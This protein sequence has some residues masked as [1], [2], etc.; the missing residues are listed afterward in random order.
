MYLGA[1][2]TPGSVLEMCRDQPLTRTRVITDELTAPHAGEVLLA[3]ERFGLSSNN[4]S[5]A[6]LGDMLGHWKPFPAAEGWGR[7]PAWGVG[8]VLAADPSVAREGARFAGYMPMATHVLMQ[9][10]STDAGLRDTSLERAGMLPLYRELRAVDDDP[11][12]REEAI[13]LELAMMPVEPLA[14]LLDEDLRRLAVTHVVISSASSKTAMGLGHLLRE[15]SVRVTGLSSPR[16]ASA[17]AG[18]ESSDTVLTYDDIDS[19]G[20]TGTIAYV[21]IAGDPEVTRSVHEH[22]GSSLTHSIGVGG[23]HLVAI[24]DPFRPDP[25]RPGPPVK[26]YSVGQRQV[27]LSEELGQEVLDGLRRRARQTL[28]GWAATHFGVEI[29]AGLEAT[30]ALW[31]QVAQGERDPRTVVSVIP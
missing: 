29:V 19:L 27:E 18:A 21:D 12:W 16:G 6:L 17:V 1:M 9:A 30:R 23:S 24:D 3:V 25:T 4:I 28:V 20:R 22:L 5:Y 31:Q 13:D 11:I 10:E 14:A 7:V 15:R 2:T 8:R 26:R